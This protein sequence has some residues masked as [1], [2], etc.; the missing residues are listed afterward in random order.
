MWWRRRRR[1]RRFA[2]AWRPTCIRSGKSSGPLAQFVIAKTDRRG[3]VGAMPTKP[4]DPETEPAET[5]HYHG[6]RERLR[7]RF[8]GAGPDA[9]SDYELL[10]MALFPAL[11]RRDTKP[12]AKALLK[13]FGSFAEV[14][15]APVAR[16]REVDGIGEASI[17]QIKL[18]AAAASRVAKGE[19]KRKIALS[20]WNDVIEYCRTGMAF[21]DKEQFRL[22]FLDKRNQLIAD[23]IQQT[24]T[25]DHTP[26]YPREVIKRAL[27]LS[28]TA[29]ILVHNHPSGDPTPSQ[30]DIQ[31]TKAIIDIATPLGISVHDH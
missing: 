18:L 4:R 8:Y 31:M 17:N 2:R 6:H 15:H 23:E 19:I 9:L 16:L 10:E 20:S 26:V 12:L 24:G 13:K 11:P 21:A 22:L 25:I 1:S 3:M 29:L 14:I 27:E 30:A 5:P 28:A 7:E